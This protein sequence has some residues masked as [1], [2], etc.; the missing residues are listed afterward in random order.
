MFLKT[1]GVCLCGCGFPHNFCLYFLL[2]YCGL[3]S[4]WLARTPTKSIMILLY[5]ISLI[6]SDTIHLH[7]LYTLDNSALAKLHKEPK[8]AIQKKDHHTQQY[9]NILCNLPAYS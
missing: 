7:N 3:F 4:G 5:S 9:T 8:F 1:V 2:S 6:K